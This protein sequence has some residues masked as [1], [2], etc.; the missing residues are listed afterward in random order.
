MSSLRIVMVLKKSLRGS[1]LPV[2]AGVGAPFASRAIWS[3]E[4]VLQH[5]FVLK[6]SARPQQ[7]Q[8][9]EKLNPAGAICLNASYSQVLGAIVKRRGWCGK[10][11]KDGEPAAQE[12]K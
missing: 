4:A 10:R 8:S 6:P 5:C 1:Q 3:A 12:R 9:T 7:L 2:Q 11:E